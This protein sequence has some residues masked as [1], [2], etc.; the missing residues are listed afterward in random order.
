MSTI[1][2]G[3]VVKEVRMRKRL[4]QAYVLRE[5][6]FYTDA[7]LSR[8]ERGSQKPHVE[9]LKKLAENIDMPMPTMFYPWMEG[10]TLEMLTIRDRLIYL[11]DKEMPES[12]QEAISLVNM[13]EFKP[14]FKN[15]INLQFILSCKAQINELA[16]KKPDDTI[17]T[18]IDAMAL[19][20][21][22]FDEHS[23][24]GHML[25]FEETTLLHT[26][27]KAYNRIGK[28]DDAIRLLYRIQKGIM[29]LPEDDHEKEKKLA[30]VLLTLSDFLIQSE[31]YAEALEIC[32]LG[33]TASVKRNKGKY[34]PQFLHNV[35]KCKL[36]LGDA[37]QCL[38]LL[39]QSYFGYILLQKK[40]KAEMVLADAKQHFNVQFN[41]YQ[42]ENLVFE[43][44]NPAMAR[45]ET[46]TCDT[47]GDLIAILRQNAGM[48]QRELCEGV[49]SQANLAKFEINDV[50]IGAYYAEAFMQRF[51]RDVNQYFY[52]FMSLKEFNEKQMRDEITSRL[53]ARDYNGAEELLEDLKTKKTY[54]KGVNL[55]FVKKSEASIFASKNSHAHPEYFNMLHD[56]IKITK[57]KFDENEVDR[58]RLTYYEIILVHGMAM[59]HCES[60]RLTQGIRLYERLIDSMDKFYVDE[61]EKVRMYP[62]LL[63]A[64]SKYLGLV[65]RHDEALEIVDKGETMEVKHG[66]LTLLHS[67]AVNRGYNLCET[68]KKK[69]SVPYIALA[70]YG[71]A[72]LGQ[73]D[74]QQRTV[75]YA[76]EHLDVEFD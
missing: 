19:T 40:D 11:L 24:E 28:R 34:T 71:S 23:F 20:Y 47:I 74:N 30:K 35:A 4:Q 50:E 54:Q 18:V 12:I 5:E 49:C 17:A 36:K 26:L 72:L 42:T 21:E 57:P 37:E 14:A 39:Q 73:S 65:K 6:S 70:Y 9:K 27:A 58:Y 25:I 53:V 59:H 68:G 8:V 41:T 16:G 7:N 76:K 69:E 13:L 45:G 52:T 15:G 44:I 62:L 32:T 33:N 3:S 60:G 48:T 2:P 66:R 1:I 43:D 31:M 67:F 55:Q 22:A 63:Y 75:A 51:G 29:R 38:S 56:A 46:I 10:Q 64:Y 61:L